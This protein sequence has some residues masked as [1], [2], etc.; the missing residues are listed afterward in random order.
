[1]ES[2]V[3]GCRAALRAMAGRGGAIV[4]IS[5]IAAQKG[6][7]A[8]GAYGASK[9]AVLQYSR[10]VAR[11][12]AGRGWPIRCNAVLP[13]PIATPMLF[14]SGQTTATGGDGRAGADHVPLGRFGIAEEVARPIL[15]LAS[16]EA[17][18]ITGTGLLIDGGLSL[19]K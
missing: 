3:L 18:Y 2:V 12:A 6:W 17:R 7:P 9:A 1:V 19:V 8:R 15:F 14:P 5:S 4:N 13:G 16:D 11:Y 10:T